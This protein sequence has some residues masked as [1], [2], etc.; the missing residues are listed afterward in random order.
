MDVWAVDV[1]CSSQHVLPLFQPQ[2]DEQEGVDEAGG[3][4]GTQWFLD[5]LHSQAEGQDE[6]LGGLGGFFDPP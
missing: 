1:P 6:P 4:W 5:E 2:P 3:W